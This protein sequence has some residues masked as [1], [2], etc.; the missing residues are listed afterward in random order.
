MFDV[1]NSGKGN[2]MYYAYGISLMYYLRATNNLKTTENIF[3]RLKISEED[4]V[5]LK[6]LLSRDASQA[7]TLKQIET[8][9]E[10]ILGR[11]TRDLT[12]EHTKL[13]FKSS[14][15]DT[16]LFSSTKY[17]MEFCF[18]QSLLVNGSEL[19]HLIEND[20]SRPDADYTG[21]E[22]YKVTG[23]PEAMKEFVLARTPHVIEEFNRLWAN[24]K[25]ELKERQL[26]EKDLQFHQANLLDDIVRNE[27][28]K[29][30]LDDDDKY[31]NQYIAHLKKEY[32]WG[33]EESLMVLHRAI[34]GERMVR[35]K[36]GTIDTFYDIEIILHLHRNGVSPFYQAGN[37]E[38]IVNN[39]GNVHWTSV[40]PDSIFTPKVI[41]KEQK[42]VDILDEIQEDLGSTPLN[43]DKYSVATDWINDL[44]KQVNAIKG[45]KT[46]DMK[47]QAIEYYFQL[48]GKAVTKLA[49]SPHQRLLLNT[50]FSGFL[51]CIPEL[52]VENTMSE[53]LSQLGLN[54]G[55]L[56]A[57]ATSGNAGLSPA[58]STKD[59][60]NL[61][62]SSKGVLSQ[63][64]RHTLYTTPIYPV[65]IVPYVRENKQTGPKVALALRTMYQKGVEGDERYT[66]EKCRDIAQR[67][68]DYARYNKRNF[69]LTDVNLFQKEMDT[70]IHQNEESAKACVV[71]LNR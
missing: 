28:V 36:T 61:K 26:S 48:I 4:Q 5:R 8:I 24:K 69:V 58:E 70:I 33:S 49:S 54:S 41:T 19:S 52:L 12:A 55:G 63:F 43:I 16:P 39:Q 44:R 46:I 23:I 67:Y 64:S 42:F 20:Y 32:R 37:P 15:L 56:N 59:E 18:Q 17:G 45:C 50:L 22:I 30:F 13:E 35:N 40:I 57:V 66:P 7:F 6:T 34:Q 47:E 3:N 29:F 9:I 14:P 38:L 51:E 65:E 1:D 11:A 71:S 10:P 2:C 53:G 31:L 62:Q 27:T 21:A 68:I 25:E 60:A